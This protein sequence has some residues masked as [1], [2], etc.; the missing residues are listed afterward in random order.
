ME[1]SGYDIT[2]TGIQ[3]IP[4]KVQAMQA[5]KTPKTRKQLQG[6]I[7]MI[8]FYR[9]M[10][11]NRASLLAP[12]TALTSK[13]VPCMWMDEHQ[14][15]FDTITKRVVG[16]EVSL[17]YPDF[18]APFLI[19]TDASKTQIGAV[20]SQ[21]GKAI[22]FHSRKMNSAQQ[23]YMVTGKELLSIV[24]ILKEFRNILLGQ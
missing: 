14:K 11:K 9:N 19:H 12:L 21:N 24:A 3:P 4:K 22:A 15:S 8:D 17:A 10:W 20:M 13:N 5:I 2:R 1:C 23:N 18:N 7:G 16:R 6:F